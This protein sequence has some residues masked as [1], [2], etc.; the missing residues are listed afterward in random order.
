MKNTKYARLIANL[1]AAFVLL[2]RLVE[3]YVTAFDIKDPYVPEPQPI[4]QAPPLGTGW[5]IGI[6]AFEI[7][8]LLV[9]LGTLY[10][11]WFGFHRLLDIYEFMTLREEKSTE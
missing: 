1:V 7:F 10:L 9:N 3:L 11:C 8:L 2:Q 6:G 4:T 5:M